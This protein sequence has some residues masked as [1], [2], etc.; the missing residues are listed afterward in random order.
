MFR[1]GAATAPAAPTGVSATAGNASATVSWTAP[2][3]GGSPITSYT[4]TPHTGATTVA[5]TVVTG[6]L[7]RIEGKPWSRHLRRDLWP[8]CLERRFA[9]NGPHAVLLGLKEAL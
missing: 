6:T 9:H 5:P 8:C 3:N 2:S 7:V 1:T 4:V